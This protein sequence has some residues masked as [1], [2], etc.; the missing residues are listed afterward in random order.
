MGKLSYADILKTKTKLNNNSL[1]NIQNLVNNTY[2][3]CFIHYIESKNFVLNGNKGKLNKKYMSE[4][5]K[6]NGDAHNLENKLLLLS[7]LIK[8]K[9]NWIINNNFILN[10]KNIFFLVKNLEKLY[11]KDV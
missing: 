7:G 9:K 6:N 4:G 5:R 11:N 2:R 3:K 8:I 10:K 1:S